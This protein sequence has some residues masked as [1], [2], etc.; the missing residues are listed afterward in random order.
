MSVAPNLRLWT[1]LLWKI[2]SE[3]DVLK[4]SDR[5]KQEMKYTQIIDFRR[6]SYTVFGKTNDKIPVPL[7][8]GNKKQK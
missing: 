8:C 3:M 1:I 5:S 2:D 4:S 6:I 7:W